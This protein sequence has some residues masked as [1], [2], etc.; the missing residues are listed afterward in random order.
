MPEATILSRIERLERIIDSDKPSEF[1]PLLCCAD[2]MYWKQH[3]YGQKFG[4]CTCVL[5]FS[6]VRGDSFDP[7]S[8]F[9]CKN[10]VKK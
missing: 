7:P 1:M 5:T 10:Y 9:Y 3:N 8:D 6:W 2:C 4:Q